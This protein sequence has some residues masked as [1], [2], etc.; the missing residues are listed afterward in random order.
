MILLTVG[1]QVPFDRFVRIVDGIAPTLSEPVFAQ[2][3][4]GDYTPVNMESHNYVRPFDFND[5][6]SRC[7]LI[8]SHAGIGTVVMAQKH[9][10]PV[11]LFPRRAALGEHRND[12]QLA[13]VAALEG[14]SGM[15]IARTAEELKT[16]LTRTLEPPTRETSYPGRER[17]R[18]AVTDFIL[19][20]E[21]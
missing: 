1:T 17:L 12:H 15:Y 19:N 3:G 11:I 8:V 13:T 2:I 14:R 16:L 4:N 21:R 20:N 7:S 18:N 9:G 5:V 6:L 10:K